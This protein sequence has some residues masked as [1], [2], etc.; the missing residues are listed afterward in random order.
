M[1]RQQAPVA[2]TKPETPSASVAQVARGKELA[3]ALATALGIPADASQ[4]PDVRTALADAERAQQ[5]VFEL[6]GQIFGLERTLG[7]RDKALKTREN[8]LREMRLQVQKVNAER[9]R[10]RGSRAYAA[11]TLVRRA[12]TIRNP[13]K[14]AGKV[15]RRLKR[16]VRNRLG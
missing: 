7:F 11:V 14:F 12:A 1:S 8:R 5:E 6:K 10:L 9:A 2:A 16:I 15:K 3:A 4:T 13:R